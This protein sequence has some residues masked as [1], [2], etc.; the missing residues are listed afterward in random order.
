MFPL[1]NFPAL[2]FQTLFL[3]LKSLSMKCS[4]FQ[5]NKYLY[6]GAITLL[7][8]L[9]GNSETYPQEGLNSKSFPQ[10]IAGKYGIESFTNISSI[11]YTFNVRNKDVNAKRQWIW[12]PKTGKV[13]YHG[14]DES[15]KNVDFTYNR[16]NMDKN[17]AMTIFVDKKF[18][19]DQYWLLFPFHLVWDKNVEITNAGEK[20][21]PLSNEKGT[22]L[23]VEYKNNVGYTPNDVFELF[24]GKDNMIKEWLYRP[25]GSKE[26]SRPYSWEGNKKFDGITI[27]TE[28]NGSGNSVKVWFT[29]IK[30]VS[31]HPSK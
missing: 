31:D 1:N 18:I 28:H 9:S 2:I 5:V 10:L 19:N 30:V 11:S 12:E 3:S 26:K 15:G 25:G 20:K 13:T 24:L 14:P 6:L 29:D 17:S 22:S 4:N 7:I 27:S 23:I 21:F 8:F 16:N